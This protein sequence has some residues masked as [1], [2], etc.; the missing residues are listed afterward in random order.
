MLNLFNRSLLAAGV[1]FLAGCAAT[2]S[3]TASPG[4][5][6]RRVGPARGPPHPWGGVLD[7]L[8]WGGRPAAATTHGRGS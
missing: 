3:N 7:L 5:P 2:V 8:G 4:A 6:P 1:L